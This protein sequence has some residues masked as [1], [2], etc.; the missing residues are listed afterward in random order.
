MSTSFDQTLEFSAAQDTTLFATAAIFGGVANTD[1]DELR[2]TLEGVYA[3]VGGESQTL[4][5]VP[6]SMVSRIEQS[7]A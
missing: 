6:W 4:Y 3:H 1:V 7:T 2:F 5:F